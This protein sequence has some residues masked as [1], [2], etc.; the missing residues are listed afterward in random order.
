MKRKR[1]LNEREEEEKGRG[2]KGG[3]KKGTGVERLP[4]WIT[5][6]MKWQ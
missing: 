6:H 5:C 1:R 4:D 2:V 3:E